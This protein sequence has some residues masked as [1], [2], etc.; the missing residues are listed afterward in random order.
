[1]LYRLSW[2]EQS[3]R[4]GKPRSYVEWFE[5]TSDGRAVVEANRR[6]PNNKLNEKLYNIGTEVN[7]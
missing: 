4:N 3:E 1:M 6:L 5:A 2:N 7:L